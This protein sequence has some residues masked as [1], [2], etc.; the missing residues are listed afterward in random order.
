MRTGGP[1]AH[2]SAYPLI[3]LLTVFGAVA[4]V[5]SG[6]VEPTKPLADSIVLTVVQ[7]QSYP[8]YAVSASPTSL[9]VTTGSTVSAAIT[10]ISLN[11]FSAVTP[12]GSAWWGNLNLV[13]QV[14]PSTTSGP[15]LGM[16]PSCLALNSGGT[17][18]TTLVVTTAALTRPGSYT[19]IVVAS[20]Q[21]SPSGWVTGRSTTVLVTVVQDVYLVPAMLTVMVMIAAAIGGVAA[22][23]LVRTRSILEEP[24]RMQKTEVC[25]GDSFLSRLLP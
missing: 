2:I 8:S 10:I 4:A 22:I 14:T 23:V 15:A 16:K 12:C 18:F 7:D 21:V 9:I 17:A 19:I 5:Q 20:F 13:A 3:S 25:P 11:G 6:I 1:F 24:E